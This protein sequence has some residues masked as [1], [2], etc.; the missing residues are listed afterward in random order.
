MR[1][2]L[3]DYGIN[4]KRLRIVSAGA[5]ESQ[6]IADEMKRRFLEGREEKGRPYELVE[7]VERL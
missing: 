6:K 5:P 4:E 3:H 7:V 2:L 1:E